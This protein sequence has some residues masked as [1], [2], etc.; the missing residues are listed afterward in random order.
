MDAM[1][2]SEILLKRGKRICTSADIREFA[3]VT[4]LSEIS[5]LIN[6]RWLVPL[7]GFRGVY[8]IRDPEE[9]LRSFFKLDAFSILALALNTVLNNDWY[10]GRL[11]A[12]NLAGFDHQSISNYYVVNKKFNRHFDSAVFG[13]VVLLKT[14]A[15]MGRASGIIAKKYKGIRYNVCTLERNVADYLYLHVHGHADLDQVNKLMGYGADKRLVRKMILSCYPRH[16]AE[17]MRSLLKG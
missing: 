1:D 5:N 17:K 15:K 7:S 16:S 4:Y 8:Y 12:L 2:V 13:T 11:T 3:G 6:T 9:R 14:A 10:F